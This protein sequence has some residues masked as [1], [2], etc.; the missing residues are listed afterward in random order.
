MHFHNRAIFT[1]NLNYKTFLSG[2]IFTNV[3]SFYPNSHFDHMFADLYT[4]ATFTVT[5]TINSKE[6]GMFY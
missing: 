4:F 2:I 3:P 6:M 1:E 5:D